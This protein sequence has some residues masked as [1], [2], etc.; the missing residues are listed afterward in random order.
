MHGCFVGPPLP[1]L[2]MMQHRTMH[3]IANSD[4]QR[5]RGRHLKQIHVVKPQLPLL[6]DVGYDGSSTKQP[7]AQ[8]GAT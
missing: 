6:R 5:A 2:L 7:V 3:G 4:I 8:I 1:A